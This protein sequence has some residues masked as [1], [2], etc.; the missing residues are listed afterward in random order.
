[1][2]LFAIHIGLLDIILAQIKS[3]VAKNSFENH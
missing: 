1:M 3:A 2:T